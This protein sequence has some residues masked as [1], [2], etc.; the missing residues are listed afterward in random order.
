[1]S[2]GLRFF[3]ALGAV[4]LRLGTLSQAVSFSHASSDAGLVFDLTGASSKTVDALCA[5]LLAS[6]SSS[7]SFF[8]PW[9]ELEDMRRKGGNQKLLELFASGS[10]ELLSG[11]FYDIDLHRAGDDIIHSQIK[12]FK[13]LAESVSASAVDGFYPR[14]MK[15]TSRTLASLKNMGFKYAFS[16]ES[17]IGEAIDAQR[18][19][20]FLMPDSLLLYSV[21]G[22]VSKAASLPPASGWLEDFV[23]TSGAV[24]GDVAGSIPGGSVV[25]NVKIEGYTSEDIEALFSSLRKMNIKVSSARKLS[26]KEPAYFKE[27]PAIIEPVPGKLGKFQEL[28]LA[29]WRKFQSMASEFPPSLSENIYKMGQSKYFASPDAAIFIPEMLALTQAF[30]DFSESFDLALDGESILA[31]SN[32]YFRI[33][34][35][36]ENLNPVLITVPSE[37]V[38]AAGNPSGGKTDYALKTYFNFRSYDKG[39]EIKKDAKEDYWRL[40]AFLKDYPLEIKK[41]FV[42]AKGKNA[43]KYYCS[44]QNSGQSSISCD[45]ALN[46][47]P[48]GNPGIHM[49]TSLGDYSGSFRSSSKEFGEIKELAFPLNGRATV[50]KF[51]A[52]YPYF[53]TLRETSAEA[54]YRKKEL[55]PSDRLLTEVHFSYGDFSPSDVAKPLFEYADIFLDG[56]PNEKFWADA[57]RF[58][59]PRRDG[60]E[61]VDISALYYASGSNCGYIFAE[62]D[63]EKTANLYIARK[64]RGSDVL[65]SKLKAPDDL[66]YYV[67]IPLAQGSPAAYKWES[68]WLNTFEKGFSMYAGKAVE[69]RL[70]M[71][72]PAGEWAVYLESGGK[73]G[74][75]VYFEVK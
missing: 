37:G 67:K 63:F 24:F 55:S 31:V 11:I 14:D 75:S 2:C 57:D 26:L 28:F 12:R 30:Y 3:L 74:D 65:Y 56:A 38:I 47:L 32:G 61:G 46:V 1:V 59:D 5:Q 51:A 33:Y 19:Q 72:L 71:V 20:A 66:L 25:F 45:V 53:L 43:V 42:M 7:A 4:L 16:E 70:P 39:W 21:S 64:G 62:G 27:L 40:S 58:I 17:A 73:I 34:F 36:A 8:I 35:S 41:T 69:I 44:L 52:N 22:R 48:A 9:D 18:L 6:P 54:A 10:A 49:R 68:V 13:L 50:L 29:E 15:L 60:P 23:Q